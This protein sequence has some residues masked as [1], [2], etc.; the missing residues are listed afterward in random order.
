[1]RGGV[2]LRVLVGGLL[3]AAGIA[4]LL[5][6]KVRIPFGRLPGDIAYRS[7]SFAFYFPLTSSIVV[8][9]LLTLLFYLISRFRR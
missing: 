4:V 1:M 5:L 9:I 7:K 2:S 8:S 6:G 3:I